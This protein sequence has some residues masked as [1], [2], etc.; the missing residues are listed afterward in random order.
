[1][2]LAILNT[3]GTISCV[4]QPLA[5]MGA[6]AFAQ[7]CMAQL[8]P[9]LQAQ[10]PDLQLSYLTEL[11]FPDSASG[12]LDSTNLQPRDW[13]LIAEVILRHYTDY[14]GWVILHGTDTLDATAAALPFLLSR[15]SAEGF[16]L[17][18]LS[19]PIIL[20]GSQLPLWQQAAD[21]QLL[22]HPYSDAL[23]NLSGAVAAAQSGLT[24]VGVFFNRQLWPASRVR[25]VH[26][27]HF[28]AFAAPNAPAL[29]QYGIQPQ[30]H[31]AYWP[32][33]PASP[34]I[35]LEQPAV[36][37][38]LC[39]QLAAVQAGLP[40]VPVTLF[41]AFPATFNPALGQ[42]WLAE[43]FHA[44]LALGVK[45]VVLQGYGAGNFPSGHVQQPAAGAMYQALQQAQAQGVVV[46][47]S[48]QT[49]QGGVM[50]HSYAAGAWQAEVGVL[51]PADLTPMAA[52][53]KLSL[54]LAMQAHHGWS[55]A[56]VK[57][58]FQQNL[59]GEMHSVNRLDSRSQPS[60]LPGQALTA[61]DGSAECVNH[62][63]HGLQLWQHPP[64][65]PRQL[66]WQALSSDALAQAR[67]PLRLTLQRHGALQLSDGQG[68]SVWQSGG[69]NTTRAAVL[70][71]DGSAREG[72]LALRVYD[73]ARSQQVCQLY[74]ASPPSPRASQTST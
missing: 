49:P 48:T 31:A 55:L 54:L 22:L 11:A 43:M 67:R 53:V 42:A 32:A 40:Q 1:M 23:Q 17:A 47:G 38:A 16:A 14:D 4:G 73:A 33:A 69:D 8:N 58:L 46:V 19:R 39:A 21:G 20:T 24:G 65:Q 66:L 28:A 64:G 15:F 37:Q 29:A 50:Q 74:P 59:L 61:L 72:T 34:A 36:R 27:E 45:G 18:A 68:Q 13:C 62:P 63:Q 44:G 60:L 7:A 71:L 30:L 52:L 41:S 25:K 5:P 12:T 6:A 35:S 70:S 3:G 2:H 56:T 57:Q 9:A 26:T 10:H 51:N